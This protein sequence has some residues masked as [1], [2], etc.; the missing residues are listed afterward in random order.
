[1]KDPS[2]YKASK[3]VWMSEDCPAECEDV[4]IMDGY[5]TCGGLNEMFN[6]NI[7]K[8]DYG[9][10]GGPCSCMCGNDDICEGKACGECLDDTDY[11]CAFYDGKCI[12]SDA[13]MDP[14]GF[15]MSKFVW[16]SDE[17]PAAVGNQY[18]QISGAEDICEG[19]ACGECLDDSDYACT[20]YDGKCILSESMKDPSAY[21]ASKFVWMSEDCPAECEDVSIMDG[22]M[23]CGGLNE[24]FNGNICKFDYGLPGGPCSCMCGNDDICEGKACG[25]CLDDTDYACV[26]YD[27]KCISSDAMKDPS[28]FKMSKFFWTSDECP[29]E[30]A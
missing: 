18:A 14:S 22:Y 7:C 8:F 4:S 5:M 27:G 13:M 1:M 17:C 2:A 16:T 11:A 20:F 9:L 15:K 3:F 29:A 26:F 25:E 24:M 21:K 23:T 10:P 12:S 30:R 28:G 6:G 19:K